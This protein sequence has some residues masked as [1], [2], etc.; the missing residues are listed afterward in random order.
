MKSYYSGH[1]FSVPPDDHFLRHWSRYMRSTD[2]HSPVAISGPLDDRLMMY[3]NRTLRST[4]NL[5]PSP[6]EPNSD[7]L[8]WRSIS[9]YLFHILL[10][11][12][13]WKRNFD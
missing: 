4:D 9:S 5:S 12:E 7:I 3:L 6:I 1:P 11:V 13:D 8:D 2:N 10:V